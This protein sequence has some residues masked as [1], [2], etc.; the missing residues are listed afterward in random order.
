MD[1]KAAVG[2]NSWINPGAGTWIAARSTLPQ[3]ITERHAQRPGRTSPLEAQASRFTAPGDRYTSRPR[4]SMTSWTPPARETPSSGP[5]P[6]S[7]LAATTW[8]VPPGL[9]ARPPHN[10][11]AGPAPDRLEQ[12]EWENAMLKTLDPALT[13]DLL[14]ALAAMGHGDTIAIVD[15]NYP[16]H[17]LHTRVITLASV[18]MRPLLHLLLVT[19]H[20][21]R[22]TRRCIRERRVTWSPAVLR[23]HRAIPERAEQPPQRRESSPSRRNCVM[24][25]SRHVRVSRPPGRC[26]IER[27]GHQRPAMPIRSASRPS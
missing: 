5:W 18:N 21:A 3:I 11:S 19:L 1:D 4:K 20:A 10:P 17:A 26:P 9:P 23:G 13:P 12:T 2:A 25:V 22:A 6:R 16:A 27:F 15:A 24:D 14:W 8:Q 7:W